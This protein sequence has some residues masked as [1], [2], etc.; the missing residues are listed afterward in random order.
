MDPLPLQSR[1]ASMLAKLKD[2]MSQRNDTNLN[3][4]KLKHVLIFLGIQM[5][6]SNTVMILKVTSILGEFYRT[7]L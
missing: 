7:T 2:I 1:R 5:Y 3:L 4:L 6:P